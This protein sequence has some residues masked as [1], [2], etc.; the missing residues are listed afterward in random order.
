MTAGPRFKS[1]MLEAKPSPAGDGEMVFLASTAGGDR[2]GDRVLP[3]GI[4]LENYLSNPV[5]LWD[6]RRDMPAIGTAKVWADDAGLWMSPKFSEVNPMG[7]QIGAQVKAGE[8]RAVSIGFMPMTTTPNQLGGDDILECELLEVTLCNV[9]CNPEALRVKGLTDAP[10]PQLQQVLDGQT[11][12]LARLTAI[13]AKIDAAAA[14]ASE[15][16]PTAAESG[17]VDPPPTL[18][19]EQ[20][21]PVVDTPAPPPSTDPSSSEDE[22]AKTF[23]EFLTR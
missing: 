9:P 3:K 11:A 22:V 1:L 7:A 5:L 4:R 2:V 14:E 19:T 6:H 18:T 8:I 17:P 15:E 21:A 16:T 10:A 20:T 23:I 12:I 13:E